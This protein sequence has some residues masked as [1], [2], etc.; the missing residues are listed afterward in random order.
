MKARLIVLA[1]LLLNGGGCNDDCSLS[2]GTTCCENDGAGPRC[3]LC[4]NRCPGNF[5]SN[6]DDCNNDCIGGTSKEC[7]SDGPG[8]GDT[9]S[10]N[11]A[12]SVTIEYTPNSGSSV[13]VN[14]NTGYTSFFTNTLSSYCIPHSCHLKVWGGSSC[15]YTTFSESNIQISNDGLLVVNTDSI[16]GSHSF[17]VRCMSAGGAQM[18]YGEV[19]LEPLDC[20]ASLSDV[21]PTPLNPTYNYNIASVSAERPSNFF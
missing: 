19:R 13:T 1:A 3:F 20:S 18:M 7:D 21:S 10:P 16:S 17:C 4:S 15:T 12:S 14:S 6:N 9:L 11:T 5:D 8:G 2:G